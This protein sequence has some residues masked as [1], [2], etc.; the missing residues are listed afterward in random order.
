MHVSPQSHSKGHKV[1]PNVIAY[2]TSRQAGPSGTVRGNR[3]RA[4]EPNAASAPTAK[5]GELATTNLIYPAYRTP[6]NP[7]F[8]SLLYRNSL[9]IGVIVP[10]NNL[11]AF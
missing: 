9:T 3:G 10:G 11:E 5:G 2:V 6:N 7:L 1:L 8:I 4:E